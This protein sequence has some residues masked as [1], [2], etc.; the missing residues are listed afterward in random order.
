MCENG[1]ISFG[2]AWDGS[3]ADAAAHT[4]FEFPLR[5]AYL[6]APLWS[7]VDISDDE[8]GGEIF[9]QTISDSGDESLSTVSR[10]IEYQYNISFAGEWMLIA[11]WNN[12]HPI[13]QNTDPRVC[14][15]K[16]LI[17][18]YLGNSRPSLALY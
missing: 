8:G 14:C 1:L 4:T 11:T 17:L 6:I 3:L 2:S 9:Y 10:F 5:G 15:I 18:E 16:G 13:P 7:D 12:V